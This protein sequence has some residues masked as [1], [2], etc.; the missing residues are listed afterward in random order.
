MSFKPLAILGGH[1][2][3]PP[4]RYR[5]HQKGGASYLRFYLP[6]AIAQELGVRRDET[7]AE[8]CLGEWEDAGLARLAFDLVAPHKFR[9]EHPGPGRSLSVRFPWAE[10][11]VLGP[12][13]PRPSGSCILEVISKDM[14][15]ITFKLPVQGQDGVRTVPPTPAPEMED[16]R[17][18]MHPP[19]PEH[20]RSLA[21]LRP[22]VADEPPPQL[23]PSEDEKV[24]ARLLR[25]AEIA[26]QMPH[27]KQRKRF[28]AA[29]QQYGI[30]VTEQDDWQ[31]I[32]EQLWTKSRAGL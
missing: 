29:C 25:Q 12:L 30:K 32:A 22:S 21:R 16:A 15:G 17:A 20:R 23:E 24:H 14:S 13:L 31:I 3:V 6:A 5:I 19:S 8:F 1:P 11:S 2:A 26:R 10:D 28:L 4:L 7:G 9:C 27:S 18:R